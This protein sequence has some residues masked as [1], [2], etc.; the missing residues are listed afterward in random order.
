MKKT[1]L[2][3]KFTVPFALLLGAPVHAQS[4]A[5]LN[6]RMSQI[7]DQ[8]R[9]LVGQV[10]QLSY[11]LRETR[12]E[13]A[14]MGAAGPAKKKIGAIE[15][16]PTTIEKAEAPPPKRAKQVAEADQGIEQIEDVPAA[17]S[18]T[19]IAAYNEDGQST[20][21]NK[22]PGPK[23]F[24][25][26]PGSNSAAKPGDGGFQ[27]QVIVAP[28][29]GRS[30]ESQGDVEAVAMAAPAAETAEGLYEQS[31][32]SLLRRQF[33]DAEGGFREFL[34][35]YRDH[36]LAGNAQYWLGETYYVQGDYKQAAQ[37][38]LSGYQD[39]PKSRKAPDS[40]LKLGL[41]LNRL[42]QKQQACAALLAVGEKFPKAA[43]ARK[44]AGSE[45]QRAGC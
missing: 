38:F 28:G 15:A 27:G 9:Q 33:G 19:A 16:E 43:E 12:A 29:E 22:A 40:L 41:S 17:S 14:R 11:E 26:L 20:D 44:R 4:A 36:S 5:E 6:V 1:I 32:E 39:F 7:E 3:L 31:Y 24:G 10:E 34:G 13:L 2:L 42:G 18:E 30:V 45:A 21:P 23:I 25:V 8:M 37:S 35:K